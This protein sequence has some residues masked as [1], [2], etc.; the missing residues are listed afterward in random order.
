MNRRTIREY[1]FK[2]IFQ[3]EFYSVD[4]L[5]EQWELYLQE[6]DGS[7]KEKNYLVERAGDIVKMSEELDQEIDAASERWRIGRMGKADLSILRLAVYEICHDEK[8]PVGAAINEAVE[9]A[10]KYGSDE[11]AY[12]FI[13]G[14]LAKFVRDKGLSAAAEKPE[15][16]S[17]TDSEQ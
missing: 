14:I 6:I 17:V 16:E 5:P 8:I 2:L 1:V 7:Q 12:S 9:L 10:K 11:R 4:E 15:G 3:K 13:N